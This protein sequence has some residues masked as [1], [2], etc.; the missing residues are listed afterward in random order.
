MPIS[1]TLLEHLVEA[2]PDIVVATDRDGTVAYYNDG[3]RENFGY[4]REE[5]MGQFVARLYPSLEE[6]RRVMAAMRSAANGGSG[7]IVNFPTRFVAKDGHE[8]PVAISGV[9]IYD[10]QRSEKGTV[11]FAKDRTNIIRKDQLALLGEVA[12]G[13][14]H[15]INNPLS[16]ITNQLTLLE[17]FV[18]E[19]KDPRQLERERGRIDIIKHEVKR[20]EE[21]LQRLYQMAQGEHYA[22]T[23]Y[24]GD[25][26]MIDLSETSRAAEGP[27][28]GRW[29]LV[30]DDDAAVRDSVAEILRVEGCHVDSA[31]DGR[32][33][34]ARLER[35]AF[36]IVLS[37]VVMPAMDGYELFQEVRQ[38]YPGTQVVLMTAFYYDK[39][40]VIKRSQMEGVAGVIFKKPVDPARLR[41]TL[42]A[43]VSSPR[44]A[45]FSH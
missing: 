37:D 43:L 27:L 1:R 7:R 2:S 18:A 35:A 16:V 15:E 31:A 19:L 10:D 14:S 20:I 40:H 25:A 13:L 44:P 22:S 42:M 28:K 24:L 21:H 3:A 45:P 23:P 11:G 12:V 33:A 39:D 30:V 8:I 29:V 36:D 4:A 38:R 9:I 32:A 17:R 26:R 34:L 5:I 6:A 41:Q